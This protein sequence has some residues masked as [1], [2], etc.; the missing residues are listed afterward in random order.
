MNNKEETT[1]SFQ[2]SERLQTKNFVII[3][4][5]YSK[6]NRAFSGDIFAVQIFNQ[7]VSSSEASRLFG[8]I[9]GTSRVNPLS[10]YVISGFVDY[11]DDYFVFPR[12][13][14]H[15]SLNQSV[16]T[17]SDDYGVFRFVLDLPQEVGN[18]TYVVTVENSA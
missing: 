16:V 2:D 8:V 7:G 15:L 11:S 4:S 9:Q 3:G 13:P 17:T 5:D 12:E 6:K 1:G 14:V 18:Y 10:K